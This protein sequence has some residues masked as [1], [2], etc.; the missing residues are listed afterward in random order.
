M[1][2]KVVVGLLLALLLLYLVLLGQRGV[3]L[4]TDGTPA[5]A[6]LGVGVLI[7]PVVVVWAIAREL[8]FGV[9]TEKMAH[10]AGAGGAPP[11]RRPAP[12]RGRP[13]RQGRRRRR[14]RALPR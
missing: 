7:L 11:P 2:T 10:R 13:H 4:I 6:V 9:R 5:G 12:Q 8:A 1:K 14:L 3:V